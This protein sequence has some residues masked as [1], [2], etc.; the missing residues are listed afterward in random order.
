MRRTCY[1]GTVYNHRGRNYYDK[2]RGCN[3]V[4]FCFV[5][6]GFFSHV[7]QLL[8]IIFTQHNACCVNGSTIKHMQKMDWK[9]DLPT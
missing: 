1:G 5:F 4:V 2:V 6:L 7:L 8:L 3:L 9:S